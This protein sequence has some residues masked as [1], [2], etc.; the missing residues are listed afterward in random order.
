MQNINLKIIKSKNDAIE[1]AKKIIEIVSKNPTYGGVSITF[2]DGVK[3]YGEQKTYWGQPHKYYK[4][5]NYNRMSVQYYE[6][7][8]LYVSW[9]YERE[10]SFT[11]GFKVDEEYIV[12]KLW[13]NRKA[14]NLSLNEDIKQELK[15]VASGW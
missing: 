10:N 11:H 9:K 14:F 12:G 3:W 15:S 13:D 4:V 7:D 2:Q 1:N 6:N 5:F 8:G